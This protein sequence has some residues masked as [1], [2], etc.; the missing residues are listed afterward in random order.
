MM[1]DLPHDPVFPA[2]SALC[3][4]DLQR[5]TGAPSV[6]VLRF[7]HQPGMR[8]VL[9]VSLCNGSRRREGVIW[10]LWPEKVER[11]RA[12]HPGLRVD[13]PT[14]ALF[15]AF[16][17]DHRLPVLA[18]FMADRTTIARQMFGMDPVAD[19][20]LLRYRPGL[21]ATFRWTGLGGGTQFLK[22]ARK[23][24]VA[25]QAAVVTALAQQ[26]EGSALSVAPVS[27]HAAEHCVIAYR[28]AEGRPFDE[29]FQDAEPSIA[30][31]LCDR[32][33]AALHDLRSCRMDGL[34]R[35]FKADYI[36]RA[37][38]C[39]EII[40]TA[41]A[42]AGCIAQER[43]DQAGAATPHL[44]HVP[45]HADM[46]LDHAFLTESCV[47]L[48]DTESLH[49]GDPDHDL[50]LLDA[51]LDLSLLDGRLDGARIALLRAA[52]RAA[53]GPDYAWF[54]SLARLHAAKFVAQRLRPDRSAILHRMLAV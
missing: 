1:F 50:A 44:R 20:T 15:E 17:E 16:P 6:E 52:L 23:A 38:R 48:I 49:L 10:F 33:V 3:A 19:P 51:R 9:H 28:S 40:A 4:D 29:M 30:H 54:L 8:A 7:R 22:V 36:R 47:T 32:F 26:L 37:A 2:L 12:S 18:R 14:G 27:G 21:S 39:V 11:L 46:K 5:I 45:I 31:H 13:G 43:L 34:P 35:L 42:S 53:A 41:D 24:K 25:E